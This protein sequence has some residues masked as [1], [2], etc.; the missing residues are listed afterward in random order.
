[1]FADLPSTVPLTA[2]AV[3]PRVRIASPSTKEVTAGDA[4]DLNGGLEG[5][6][7]V[8]GV[9]VEIQRDVWPFDSRWRHAA[10]GVTDEGGAFQISVRTHR[11]TRYR[12]VAAG[13]VSPPVRVY[14]NL[15]AELRRS[16]GKGPTFRA[17]YTIRA[18]RD[19]RF[20]AQAQFYVFRLGRHTAPLITSPPLR[21]VRP[22]RFRATTTLRYVRPKRETVV[23]VCYREP[24]PDA[25]GRTET[26]DKRCGSNPLRVP[27]D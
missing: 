12:A 26:L 3:A 16:T 7:V 18:P 10:S 4:R 15:V 9:Q 11:N 14:A 24:T 13:L 5:T 20:P 1:M 2:G 21:R 19:A 22:G 23:I 8:S 27:D 6:S 25:W 17:T